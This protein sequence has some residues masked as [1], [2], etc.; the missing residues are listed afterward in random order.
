MEGLCHITFGLH[1]CA[2][3]LLALSTF[4]EKPEEKKV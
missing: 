1:S 3:I 4:F 2:A